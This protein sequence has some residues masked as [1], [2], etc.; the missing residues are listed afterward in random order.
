VGGVLLAA[1]VLTRRGWQRALA[2]LDPAAPHL[3]FDWRPDAGPAELSLLG[4]EVAA[5]VDGPVDTAACPHPGGPPVCWCRPPLP[6]LPLAFARTHGV[7]L[8]R[9]VLF[10][11]S[12]AHRT[13]ATTLGARSIG[14]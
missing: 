2:E 13:L 10:G 12:A 9:S 6:G 7:D 4:R 8:A 14:V 1:S 11:T 3:L 5:V